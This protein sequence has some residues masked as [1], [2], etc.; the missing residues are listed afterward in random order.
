MSW[1]WEY[2][3]SVGLKD[4]VKCGCGECLCLDVGSVNFDILAF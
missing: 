2:V 1:E 3:G 4:C